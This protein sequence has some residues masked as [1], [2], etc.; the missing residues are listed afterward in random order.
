MGGY[1]SNVN[2]HDATGEVCKKEDMGC[3]VNLNLSRG[4]AIEEWKSNSLRRLNVCVP[5]RIAFRSENYIRS[6]KTQG[7]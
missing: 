2:S 5:Y 3:G 4:S 7:L 1:C 6:G